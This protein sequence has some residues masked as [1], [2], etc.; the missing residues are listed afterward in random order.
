[1]TAAALLL[2]AAWIAWAEYRISG[3]ETRLNVLESENHWRE[4][5]SAEEARR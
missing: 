2:T 4:I 5:P 3:L 1:M